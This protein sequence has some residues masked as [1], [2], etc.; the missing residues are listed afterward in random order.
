MAVTAAAAAAA[1]AEVVTP[2]DLGEALQRPLAPV[3]LQVGHIVEEVQLCVLVQQQAEISVLLW[4]G[5][6]QPPQQNYML[7]QSQNWTF[8]LHAR[9][10]QSCGAKIAGCSR[11]TTIYSFSSS[12]SS[13]SSSCSSSSVLILNCIHWQYTHGA[14]P[15]PRSLFDLEYSLKAGQNQQCTNPVVQGPHMRHWVPN[16]LQENITSRADGKDTQSQS[17]TCR[18]AKLAAMRPFLTSGNMRRCTTPSTPS[19]SAP[20]CVYCCCAASRHLDKACAQ[21]PAVT[22]DVMRALFVQGMLCS[23]P[24][25][26][27]VLV[28]AHA[29]HDTET[30][31]SAGWRVG[32]EGRGFQARKC[33]HV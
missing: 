1:A 7:L 9:S 32:R 28:A 21:N 29:A 8:G 30:G 33:M 27:G 24:L 11:M 3:Q 12:C 26:S 13:S 25:V 18:T 4:E 20:P 15:P 5:H 14:L 22:Q 10:K 31:K 6:H 16:Y 17:L 2:A 19:S 23:A